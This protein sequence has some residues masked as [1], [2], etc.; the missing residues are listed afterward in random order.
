MRFLSIL[1][2]ALII[3]GCSPQP[4]GNVSVPTQSGVVRQDLC[5]ASGG[6]GPHFPDTILMGNVNDH[7]WPVWLHRAAGTDGIFQWTAEDYYI[8]WPAGFSAAFTPKLVLY[9]E[10][11]KIIA[12]EG[13]K[14]HLPEVEAGFTSQ[15]GARSDPVTVNGEMTVNGGNWHCY[16]WKK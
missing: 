12:R 2:L 6:F 16:Y 10:Q 14:I 8:R 7:A 3:Q 5:A 9:D 13:D 4:V 11:G 1:L 15:T